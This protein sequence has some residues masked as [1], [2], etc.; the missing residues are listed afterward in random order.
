METQEDCCSIDLNSKI[1]VVIFSSSFRQCQ[2]R[3]GR[4]S[5]RFFCPLSS[6]NLSI[7][8]IP[9]RLSKLKDL[10]QRDKE[11]QKEAI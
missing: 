11:K 6:V 3:Q 5:V 9:F 7:Q 1:D 4:L 8:S 10:S 2:N